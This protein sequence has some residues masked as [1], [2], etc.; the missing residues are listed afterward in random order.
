MDAGV[1]ASLSEFLVTILVTSGLVM[2]GYAI[3]YYKIKNL[4]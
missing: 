4:I 1:G 2:S 3:S